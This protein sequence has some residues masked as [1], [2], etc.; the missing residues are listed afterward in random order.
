MNWVPDFYTKQSLW[1]GTLEGDVEE[2][3]RQTAAQIEELAGSG[4]KRILE[5]GAGGGQVAAAMADLGHD[6]VAVELVPLRLQKAALLAQTQRNG[7][8]TFIAGDFYEVDLDGRFDVVCYWDG[9]GIGADADQRRLLR[10]IASEW[11]TAEGCALIDVA[12][13]WYPAAVAGRGWAVG[14]AEREYGFDGDG[15]RWLDRWWPKG[16]PEEAVEQ[17]TRCYSPAD[18]RL[19]LESTGL[20]L[21]HVKPGG[22]MDWSAGKWLPA[23]PIGRAMSYVAKLGRT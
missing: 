20:T 3:H 1:A 15:C 17:S 10:R 19:L 2:S 8:L 18:L 4:T 13:P 12:T 5:L 14:E 16:K 6:V 23:V 11:L 21:Q 7:A 9:F 22:V